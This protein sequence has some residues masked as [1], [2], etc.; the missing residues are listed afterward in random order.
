MSTAATPTESLLRRKQEQWEREKA[1]SSV[2]FP[3][4]A[5][6]GGA[7]NRKPRSQ[8]NTPESATKSAPTTPVTP[9]PAQIV[10]PNAEVASPAS[11][12]PSTPQMVTSPQQAL[13]YAYLPPMPLQ[14]PTMYGPPQQFVYAQSPHGHPIPVEVV[15]GPHGP[16]IRYPVAFPPA[17]PPNLTITSPTTS[18]AMTSSYTEQ[19]TNRVPYWSNASPHEAPYSPDS[20]THLPPINGDQSNRLAADDNL[21]RS[22]LGSSFSSLNSNPRHRPDENDDK[23][24]R[25]NEIKNAYEAQI[26]E[27]KKRDAEQYEIERCLEQQRLEERRQLEL[28]LE[29]ESEIER[30]KGKKPAVVD[31]AAALERFKREAEQLKKAKLY[32][33]VMQSPED[34]PKYEAQVFGENA[35]EKAARVLK[36]VE[37]LERQKKWQNETLNKS[38]GRVAGPSSPCSTDRSRSLPPKHHPTVREDDDRPI[39]P[40]L[41]ENNT[42]RNLENVATPQ[43][44]RLQR[45]RSVRIN[46]SPRSETPR[47]SDSAENLDR[48]SARPVN[49]KNRTPATAPANTPESKTSVEKSPT[50]SLSRARRTASRNSISDTPVRPLQPSQNKILYSYEVDPHD[51]MVKSVDSGVGQTDIDNDHHERKG[52]IDSTESSNASVVA[53]KPRV[54]PLPLPPSRSNLLRSKEFGGSAG[55][56]EPVQTRNRRMRFANDTAPSGSVDMEMPS[57]PPT[58]VTPPNEDGLESPPLSAVPRKMS[59]DETSSRFSFSRPSSGKIRSRVNSTTN[60]GM[61]NTDSSS[62]PRQSA[63]AKKI[64]EQSANSI[65]KSNQTPQY[66]SFNMKRNNE[67]QQK[68]L[69]QL[70]QLRAQLK[71]KQK[72]IG[73]SLYAEL[74]RSPPK[75]DSVAV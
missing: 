73:Q 68:I 11:Q 50:K 39:R 21:A 16:M 5:P 15:Q 67:S 46:G 31:Q 6:G 25:L 32:R 60:L 9:S 34:A 13:P 19:W 56:F 44:S 45:G 57:T 14:S 20:R 72:R 28:Q 47:R 48:V 17:T 27:K 33:H 52:S 7:P 23:Q 29:R 51:E 58:I 63:F 62:P 2:W 43:P 65:D 26:Q 75:Q 49:P 71:D 64:A 1:E 10:A 53:E 12:P 36:E 24:H 3:F 41:M 40:A 4:G 69:D 18:A 35:C 8:L 61:N 74:D 59:C 38:P 70:A 66:R 22:T 42:I 37:Q 54:P 55:L 30:T